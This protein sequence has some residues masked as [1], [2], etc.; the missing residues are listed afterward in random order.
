[1]PPASPMAIRFVGHPLNR[2]T[3]DIDDDPMGLELTAA[4]ALHNASA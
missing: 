2:G 3:V 1:M 4:E